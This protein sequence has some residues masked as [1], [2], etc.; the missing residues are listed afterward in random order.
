VHDVLANTGTVEALDV[1]SHDQAMQDVRLSQKAK[2]AIASDPAETLY[3][4]GGMNFTEPDV[5]EKAQR[6]SILNCSVGFKFNVRPNKL[7]GKTYPVAIEH[8]AL[9]QQ[10]WVYGLPAFGADLSGVYDTD[11][12]V[13]WDGVYLSVDTAEPVTEPEH[14]DPPSGSSDGLP[15]HDADGEVTPATSSPG[16]DTVPDEP[17]TATPLEQILAEQTARAERLEAELEA[18]RQ[19]TAS[20][21]ALLSATAEQLHASS[22]AEKVKAFQLSGSVPPAVLVRAE[23]LYL[24]DKPRID[25]DETSALSLSAAVQ[26]ENGPET[27]EFNTVTEVVDFLLSAM[28]VPEDYD[29]AKMQSNLRLAQQTQQ[30][31]KTT[32]QKVDEIERRVHP[33]RFNDDGT[34]KA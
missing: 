31:G 2:D 1:L 6:G 3:M 9:T 29:P 25:A 32:T 10:P 5:R 17:T 21:N 33:D 8:V 11:K 26:G 13:P 16:D 34:R 24:S 12:D 30:D 28:P 19:R 22:V 23:A 20:S 7:T 27:Q 15:E 4:L 18:E 14:Q